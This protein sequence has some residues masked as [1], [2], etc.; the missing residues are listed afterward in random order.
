VIADSTGVNPV[1]GLL[2]TGGSN[3]NVLPAGYDIYRKVGDV[4]NN[5]SSDFREFVTSG[6]GSVRSIQYRDA[7]SSRQQLT[8]GAATVVT[9]I[10]CGSLIPNGA[11]YGRF[12]FAQRGTVTAS[13]YDDPTQLLAN[14]QRS[15]LANNTMGDVIMRV[16]STQRIAYANAAAGGLVDV[17]ITGYEV[18]L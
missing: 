4:R 13:F 12:Q 8:G 3:P 6:N 11:L 16:T 1:A 14:A 7:I 10:N 17:W 2:S 5:S 15:M 9:A 18:Q